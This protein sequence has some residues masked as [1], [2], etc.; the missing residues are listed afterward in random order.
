MYVCMYVC[1]YVYKCA[2]NNI[3]IIDYSLENIYNKYF[4]MASFLFKVYLSFLF[5]F[6]E[7]HQ[8]LFI[9]LIH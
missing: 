4:Q 3:H 2:Y 7:I 5:K 1:M 9:A 8:I 6:T